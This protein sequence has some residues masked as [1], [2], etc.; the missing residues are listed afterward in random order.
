[1]ANKKTNS[2]SK[3]TTSTKK[4]QTKK[5]ESKKID[6]VSS[7]DTGIANKLYVVGGVLVFLLAFYLLTVYVT[8]SKE[9][10]K[11]DKE[12]ETVNIAYDKTILGRSLSMDDEEYFVIYYDYTN[13]ELSNT[14][15]GLINGYKAKTNHLPI[16]SV[17]MSNMFNKA[18]ITDGESNKN[19]ANESELLINGPTLIVVK[20]KAVTG[21]IEGQEAITNYLN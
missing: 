9:Q 16:Y 5:V 20:D 18:Y 11:N 8:R 21:Y 19:P 1:M 7:I 17:D 12:E 15:S 2:T 4:K 10:K 3:K 13:E 14:Y 6:S